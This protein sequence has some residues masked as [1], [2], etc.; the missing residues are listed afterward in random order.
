MFNRLIHKKISILS[1]TFLFFLF[2][3]I[4]IVSSANS[5]Q[6][7]RPEIFQ[8]Q[9]QTGSNDGNIT[10]SQ[11]FGL[12]DL[13][14]YA[15]GTRPEYS[16]SDGNAT[17]AQL[18][19]RAWTCNTPGGKCYIKDNLNV[20][21]ELNI[22][23]SATATS[24]SIE[25]HST[26]TD[27]SPN[28]L[29]EETVNSVFK[30]QGLVIDM[31]N[32]GVGQVYPAVFESGHVCIA[33][34]GS[35][36][37]GNPATDCPTALTIF[38]GSGIQ[39]RSP[40]PLLKFHDSNNEKYFLGANNDD[41][42]INSTD[43]DSGGTINLNQPVNLSTTIGNTPT[44]DE[45]LSF[46][47]TYNQTGLASVQNVININPT[48]TH[49][50]T[51]GDTFVGVL[52]SG[53]YTKTANPTVGLEA[54][55]LFTATPILQSGTSNVRPLTPSILNIAY[56]VRSFDNKIG[57]ISSIGLYD[58]SGIDAINNA[59]SYTTLADWS[60]VISSNNIDVDS[61]GT[62]EVQ[63]RNGLWFQ[64]YTATS[65][66]S[67]TIKL[68]NQT[69]IRIDSLSGANQSTGIESHI[70]DVTDRN[71][72][73]I[74]AIGNAKSFFSG[75]VTINN[76][77]NVTGNIYGSPMLITFG[78]PGVHTANSV[79]RGGGN[80]V[81]ALSRG[82][83]VAIRQGKVTGVSAILDLNN[84]TSGYVEVRGRIIGADNS[85]RTVISANLT[86]STIANSYKIYNN[87]ALGNT[88]F[89]AGEVL[90]LRLNFDNAVGFEV[91][92]SIATLEVV[93]T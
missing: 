16:G 63:R 46:D 5:I 67:G 20:T 51:F 62:V 83:S 33:G 71:N 14:Q 50:S 84:A 73:F 18:Y 92:D 11:W 19:N 75:K 1:L 53:K 26:D 78:L 68:G 25:I 57:T 30:Q 24:P 48:I 34:D 8:V 55:N 66:Y 59:D 58:H 32:N 23:R 56:I 36:F 39:I 3:S 31:L 38:G 77:L 88:T 9:N 64:N 80:S 86:T 54:F 42:I 10:L 72:W 87:T 60:S 79:Y 29:F 4:Q 61:S 15:N 2:I 37:A 6:I 81:L 47:P 45:I 28:L 74:R 41:F 7:V 44:N 90:Q 35:T 89:F 27:G 82:G 93:Y 21:G 91:D 12:F 22:T 65:G 13:L 40:S 52:G 49:G 17:L 70:N 85:A 43:S 69:A 76:D